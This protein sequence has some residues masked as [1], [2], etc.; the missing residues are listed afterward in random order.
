MPLKQR[1]RLQLWHL[2]VLIALASLTVWSFT[3]YGIVTAEIEISDVTTWE[4]TADSAGKEIDVPYKVIKVVFDYV[5]PEDLSNSH[6]SL[7]ISEPT[8]VAT[9]IKL[10]KRF[11]FRY[12]TKRF[13]WLE[14]EE[15][16]PIAIQLLGLER[17]LI[18]E[19]IWDIGMPDAIE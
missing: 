1:M 8:E 2:F 13:L 6:V 19:V 3:Q 15:P 5:K 4:P 12:R 7:F 9:E 17:H 16:T 10:G 18:E 11:K 14:P